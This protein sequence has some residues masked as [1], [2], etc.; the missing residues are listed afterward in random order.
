MNQRP[1]SV[2]IVAALLILAG[3]IGFAYHLTEFVS[4]SRLQSDDL[5]VLAVRLLAIAYGVFLLRGRN[6]ARWLAIAWIAYH[7]S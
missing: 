5:W 2:T 6:W 4:R 3:M 7:V 1:L